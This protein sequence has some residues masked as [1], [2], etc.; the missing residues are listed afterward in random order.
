MTGG[1]GQGLCFLILLNNAFGSM[2]ST[3]GHAPASLAVS[4]LTTHTHTHSLSLV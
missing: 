3:A 2:F 4:L 1:C